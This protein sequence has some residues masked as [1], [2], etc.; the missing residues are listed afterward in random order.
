MMGA[1]FGSSPVAQLRPDLG[2]GAVDVTAIIVNYNTR[3]LLRP[4]IDALRASAAGLRLQIVIID[5]ASSDGSVQVIKADYADCDL[6][7][8]ETNVGFGRANNQ[9]LP[10]ARGRYLLLLNTDAFVAEESLTRTL[11]FLEARPSCALLGVRL[12]GRDGT[13]QPS[14]RYFPTPWNEFLQSTGLGRFFPGTQPVD[15]MAWDHASP[16]ECDWVPGCYY[17]VR[18]SVVDQVGLFDP[19]YF[20]YNEEVDH[21]RA[22]KAA[23]WQVMYCPDTTVVHIGG[24]SAK[25][26]AEITAGGRQ[27][28]ALQ[29]ESSLLYYRKHHGR[30]GLWASVLL[31]T[32][33]DALLA[34]KALIRGRPLS[35]ITSCWR[36]TAM[37]WSSLLAT[38]FGML[39]TR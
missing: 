28:S 26:D 2:G 7:F 35:A 20:L 14:C 9:A 29:T 39:P 21:C 31:G 5:N 6:L 37:T 34:L 12:V 32:S 19:R 11:Q 36:H 10:I 30:A 13:L 16:R 24:E 33:A 15:N 1:A 27:N 18:K 25:F 4:C 8:N 3:D 23:G 17:L 22:V 38:R